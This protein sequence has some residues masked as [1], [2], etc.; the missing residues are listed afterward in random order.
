MDILDEHL[1]QE[2]DMI[3]KK[4]CSDGTLEGGSFSSN[5]SNEK[6]NNHSD[7]EEEK[8][9]VVEED[10]VATELTQKRESKCQE[11]RQKLMDMNWSKDKART[12]LLG[13][14]WFQGRTGVCCNNSKYEEDSD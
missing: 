13:D 8:F 2:N 6:V 3:A 10:P 14:Q 9:A 5:N 11:L 7:N 4:I 1:K 12:K